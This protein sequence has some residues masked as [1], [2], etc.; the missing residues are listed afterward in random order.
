M[1]S[2]NQ[3]LAEENNSLIP[4]SDEQSAAGKKLRRRKR[5]RISPAADSGTFPPFRDWSGVLLFMM[6]PASVIFFSKVFGTPI[7]KPFLYGTAALLGFYLV[8]RSYYNVELILAV[9]LLYF[10]FSKTIVIP[11]APGLNGTNV[12]L[13][14]VL[15]AGFFQAQRGRISLVELIPGSKVVFGFAILSAISAITLSLRPGGFEYFKSDVW[16]IFKAWLDQFV[17]YFVVL[18]VIR[19]GDL[20]KR[21]IL[22]MIIGSMLVVIYSI[23]EMLDKRGY[24]NLDKARVGGPLGQPNNFG[25]FVAYTM[26]PIIALFTVY[27]DKIKAWFIIPYL[28]LALK[29]LITSF[30]R[31]A[32][33][34]LAAG[35]LLL[36]YLRGKGFIFFWITV[37]LV[38][39]LLFPSLVPESIVAR[40][41]STEKAVSTTSQQ[42][43]K[44][45]Q[46]R[47][48]MWE[49]AIEMTAESP[50]LGKGFKAFPLLKEQYTDAQVHE[51]DPHSM[52]FYISSQMGIPALVFFL[53]MFMNMFEMGRKLSCRAEDPYVRAVGLGG[54]GIAACMA[55]INIFGSRFINLDFTCYFLVY[56]VVLQYLLK[57]QNDI[58]MQERKKKRRKRRFAKPATARRDGRV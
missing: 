29:L 51:S 57:E 36:G 1:V 17:L 58:E 56:Y 41:S 42:L 10:P 27:I 45:S 34:A 26:L 5:K 11:V 15:M 52:Y 54:A 19:D 37:G 53:L 46:T 33:V 31:G 24:S 20:A 8:L 13:L 55:I 38:L 40:M 21:V 35:G 14:L 12:F 43:D 44:S 18:S 25:G 2:T 28:L 7:P 9:A 49:A 4:V 32:Y 47:L 16:F 3:S 50:I 23:P 6:I 39:V 22:Y 30:S 48:I